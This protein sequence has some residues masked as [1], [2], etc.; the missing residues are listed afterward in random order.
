MTQFISTKNQRTL[1][2]EEPDGNAQKTG[3]T[4]ETPE[5]VQTSDKIT[6][7]SAES[8]RGSKGVDY[9][10]YLDAN[11]QFSAIFTKPADDSKGSQSF[12]LGTAGVMQG[13]NLQIDGDD[14]RWDE[15]TGRYRW[16]ARKGSTVLAA[17]YAEISPSSGFLGDTDMGKMLKTPSQFGSDWAVSY[18]FY[19]SGNGK[20]SG[21]TNQDQSYVYITRDQSAWMGELARTLGSAFTDK[22]FAVFA[23]PGSHDAGMFDP[24][25]LGNLIGSTAFL[26][27]LS[28]AIGM[29]L[30]GLTL[31][32]INRA[33]INF[34]MTQ[35]DNITDQLKLGVRY[36]DFRP[37]RCAVPFTGVY[38]QHAVIPGYPYQQFLEDVLNFLKNHP[39]EIVVVSANFQG[40][41]QDRMKPSVSELDGLLAAAQEATGTKTTIVPGDKNSLRTPYK[42]LIAAGK[43]L[44]FLNQIGAGDDASKY[45]SYT[46]AYK[47]TDVN[48]ILQALEEMTS[49]GQSNCDYTVLQL[50]GTATGLSG[51]QFASIATVSDASSPLL[52]T[53]PGF[54]S[55]TY[56][57]LEANVASRLSPEKLL[58]FLNDFADNALVST[59]IAVTKQRVTGAHVTTPDVCF[60]N[61]KNTPSGTVELRRS[62]GAERY[63]N[64]RRYTTTL[65][66]ADAGNGLFQVVG[67][68]LWFIKTK[69]TQ[70]GW[71]EVHQRTLKSNFVTGM[72]R[73]VN[74]RPEIVSDGWLQMV[75]PDLWFIRTTNTVSGGQ[76]VV[77]RFTAESNYQTSLGNSTSLLS[78][79]AGNGIF[80][81]VGEDLW[82]IQTKNTKSGWIEVHQRTAAS[83]YRTGLDQVTGLRPADAANGRLQIVGADL[84]FIQTKNVQG[85]FIRVRQFTARSRYQIGLNTEAH[86]SSRNAQ[87]GTFQMV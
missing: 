80:Q 21:L 17:R 69:N 58:V 10:A 25:L 67:S 36:F 18:G 72:D 70:S 61:T 7:F 34:G 43:R 65:S 24:K 82:F 45:D 68:D 49:S 14:I 84:W 85:G 19:D 26:A 6:A 73:A 47:T 33:A 54:D 46:D 59:A 60:I 44:I 23:L 40:F 2:S 64:G 71:V 53:K 76:V 75:G 11:G 87:D 29:I 55:K 30:A 66:P 83:Q 42:D 81:M 5:A 32:Q 28:P 39:S 15:S 77:M 57:W 27:L 63:T 56:P 50:Q 1:V 86:L 31:P 52:S 74:L 51:G 35:K 48:A 9:Y 38:H 8:L 22:P 20:L 78:S 13:G 62:Y 16:E 4:T 3:A 79:D 37:G 41:A 12:T